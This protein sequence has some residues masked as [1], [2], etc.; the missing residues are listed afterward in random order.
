MEKDKLYS[1][2]ELSKLAGISSRSL[3]FYEACNLL[4]P[5]LRLNKGRR[6]YDKMGLYRLQQVLFYKELGLTLK[7][8]SL[9]LN[10]KSFDFP[11]ALV[12]HRKDLENK[13]LKLHQQI[14]TVDKTIL[15]FTKRTI[16]KDEELYEGFTK[17][18]ISK[19]NDEVDS[20][21]NP[22][23][24]AESRRRV[25]NMNK[26]HWAKIKNASDLFTR[27]LARLSLD[28]QPDDP[29]V[30]AQIK[31]HHDWIENFYDC[32]AEMY[33]GLGE[34]YTSDARFRATYDKYASGLADFMQKAMNI[35]AD[36]NN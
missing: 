35:W 31:L 36:H 3:R 25:K 21:Y 33:R 7:E 18:E 9:I 32:N 19:I 14:A 29:L 2:T 11:K 34:L 5:A 4:S 24:V 27:E 15:H 1:I 8:I 10:D 22:K 30:Q 12:Q 17:D 28:H 13:Q 23:V 6:Y 26:E 20:K 16:M